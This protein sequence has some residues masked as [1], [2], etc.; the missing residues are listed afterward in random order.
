MFNFGFKNRRR[1]L[2]TTGLIGKFLASNGLEDSIGKSS[3]VIVSGTSLKD[4]VVNAP[5]GDVISGIGPFV[6]DTDVTISEVTPDE[7]I[8]IGP[9]G[10][11]IYS[12]VQTAN[13]TK[14]DRYLKSY[15]PGYTDVLAGML[16]DSTT[17]NDGSVI[18]L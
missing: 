12:T 17:I 1:G 5:S 3:M 18:W 14:I 2:P 16:T 15:L 7:H 13:L 11:V 6:A 4:L 8:R 9:G 10:F